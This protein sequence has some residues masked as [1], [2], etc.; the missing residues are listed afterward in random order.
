MRGIR[1]VDDGGRSDDPGRR[2]RRGRGGAGR[3]GDLGDSR[4]ARPHVVRSR[5]NHGDRDAVHG[6]VRAARRDGEAAAR[7]PAGAQSGRVVDASRADGLAYEF[8]LRNGVRFHNGDPVSAEDVKFSFER[9]RGAASKT[10]KERVAAVE[11]PGPTRVRFRLKEP[12]PD[13]LTFYSSATGAGWIVPKNYIDEGRRRRLQE[14]ADR[15]R[16]LSIRL[17]HAGRRARARG[18]RP[19]LAQVPAREAAGLQDDP[20][21]VDAIRRA[22]ARRDR[23]Q[24]LDDGVA[25]RGAPADAGAH[26]QA[27]AREQHVLGLLRRSVGPEVPVARP[28]G[29]ARREPRD[30]PAGDQPGRD[31]RHSRE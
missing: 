8:V 1:S 27:L 15:R 17:V 5:R 2:R 29:A 19:V 23:H 24:L 22:Q 18:R 9:Y 7:Q 31:A 25:R 12:W 20:G 16:P 11:I 13:F 28:P 3:S 26:A 14:G 6:D 30:R 4:L 21:P 10:F